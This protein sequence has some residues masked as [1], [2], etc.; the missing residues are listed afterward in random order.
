MFLLEGWKLPTW[1]TRGQWWRRYG[2]MLGL[3]AIVMLLVYPPFF[4]SC[5]MVLILLGA[6]VL[7]FVVP[8][9]YLH[10]RYGSERHALVQYLIT[11]DGVARPRG[12]RV[13]RWKEYSHLML[14]A[15][16]TDVWRLHVYP[17]WSRVFGPPV[18]NAVLECDQAEAE[19]VRDEIQRRISAARRAEAEAK[20]RARRGRA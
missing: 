6:G 9:L 2:P 5:Q 16:G 14:L 8:R 13:Y 15:E 17:T 3:G 12:G 11:E 4:W 18:V 10:L 19:A 7:V 1:R 20:A